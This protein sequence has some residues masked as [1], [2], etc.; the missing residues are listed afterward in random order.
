MV[1]CYSLCFYMTPFHLPE[2]ETKNRKP[3]IDI[4]MA[5]GVANHW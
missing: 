1:T 3:Q 4:T 5:F 2:E